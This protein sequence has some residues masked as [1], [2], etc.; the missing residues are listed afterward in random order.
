MD[1]NESKVKWITVDKVIPS[2]LNTKIGPLKYN[3]YS[4]LR[5]AP[6]QS[7]PRSFGGQNSNIS[8]A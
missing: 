2:P 8:S 6:G 3:V 5:V 4:Q 7:G 1:E